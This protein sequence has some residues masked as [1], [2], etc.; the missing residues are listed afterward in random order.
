M[1]LDSTCTP[2]VANPIAIAAC[3]GICTSTVVDIMDPLFYP[4]T[5]IIYNSVAQTATAKITNSGL[6]NKVVPVYARGILPASFLTA[7]VFGY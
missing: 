1:A 4:T 7:C 5:S 6:V 3:A 2:P